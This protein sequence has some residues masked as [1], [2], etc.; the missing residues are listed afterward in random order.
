MST[1]S[2]PTPARRTTLSEGA[3]AS[4]SASIWVAS[5][6]APRARR[7]GP[8]AA[9]GGR[10]R[11]RCARRSRA[12][13]VDRGGRRVLRREHDGL[14]HGC[15]LRN[16]AGTAR[17]ARAP[18]ARTGARPVRAVC[19][20]SAAPRGA[21]P[22]DAGRLGPSTTATHGLARPSVTRASGIS[23]RLG[24]C[25]RFGMRRDDVMPRR[26]NGCRH[27]DVTPGR[28]IGPG[29]T[30]LRRGAHGRR[31]ESPASAPLEPVRRRSVPTIA[32]QNAAERVRPRHRQG[33]SPAARRAPIAKATANASRGKTIGRM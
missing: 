18:P 21:R 31:P 15:V 22:Y 6:R 7:R 5:A 28:P 4:A 33:N 20:P 10:S 29:T 27:D 16:G 23:R 12:K 24:F 26:T 8:R 9:R 14:R 2:R 13:R 25:P 30:P 17:T 3:A 19:Q 11:R 1:L 32:S